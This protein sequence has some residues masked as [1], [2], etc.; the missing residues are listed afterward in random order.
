MENSEQKFDTE[1][2]SRISNLKMTAINLV[3][4]LLTGQHRSLTKG[5]RWNLRNIRIIPQVMK[6]V[7]STGRWQVKPIN[8]MSS[9]SRNLPT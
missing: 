3:E 2:L 1:V 9:N 4:G 7:I 5:L 6:F 8:I